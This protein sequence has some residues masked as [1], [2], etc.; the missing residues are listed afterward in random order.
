MR[1]S[2]DKKYIKEEGR[3]KI[4]GGKGKKKPEGKSVNE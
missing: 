4:R 3:Q 2:E 1:R